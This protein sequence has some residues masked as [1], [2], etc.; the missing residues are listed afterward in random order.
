MIATEAN[1][2]LSAQGRTDMG[3]HMC[4]RFFLENKS[5][6]LGILNV[7]TIRSDPNTDSKLIFAKQSKLVGMMHV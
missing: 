6:L 1:P 4:G 2:I 5:K 7:C 3:V